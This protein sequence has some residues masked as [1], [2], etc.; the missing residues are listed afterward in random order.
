MIQERGRGGGPS[1]ERSQLSS[2]YHGTKQQHE[3]SAEAEDIRDRKYLTIT[4]R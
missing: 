2:E 4:I 3:K 1:R